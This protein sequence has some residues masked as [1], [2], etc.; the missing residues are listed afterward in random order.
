MKKVI[1]TDEEWQQL[2]DQKQF[3][4]TRRHFTEP[5]YSSEFALSEKT[6]LYSCLCCKEPLF[7]S[8][9]KLDVKTGWP[10]F[11]VPATPDAVREEADNSLEV[12]RTAVICNCCDAFLGHVFD[13]GPQPTGLRYSINS[14]ALTFEQREERAVQQAEPAQAT[15]P[16]GWQ[17]A[18]QTAEPAEQE[19]GCGGGSCGCK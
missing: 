4:V 3:M 5:P 7:D 10:S 2:L 9:C 19:G 12:E 17:P 13:D 11:F 8:S 6:G 1:K 18:E 16:T 15:Q 14:F